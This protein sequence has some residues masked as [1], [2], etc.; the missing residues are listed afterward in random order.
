[1]HKKL[2]DKGWWSAQ[3]TTDHDPLQFDSQA[4]Q[5]TWSGLHFAAFWSIS[6]RLH[7]TLTVC[8]VLR[9][10]KP[11]LHWQQKKKES[12]TPQLT[13]VSISSALWKCLIQ[14]D[15]HL[16]SPIIHLCIFSESQTAESFWYHV[17]F[18]AAPCS[19]LREKGREEGDGER[20]LRRE[21]RV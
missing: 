10:L 20:S 1:M 12:K 7:Q 8:S 9:I 6:I 5:L 16:D 4:Q 21:T 11:H 2:Q 13:W 15:E 14:P 3:L 19:C 17:Y 18:R